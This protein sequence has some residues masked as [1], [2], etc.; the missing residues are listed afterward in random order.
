MYYQGYPYTF[1]SLRVLRNYSTMKLD[2]LNIF[3][4]EKLCENM[5][6]FKGKTVSK[7]VE[8]FKFLTKGQL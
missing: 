8:I 3:E 5:L 7:F 1:F 4:Q 6:E 2:I